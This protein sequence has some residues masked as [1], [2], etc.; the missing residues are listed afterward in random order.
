MDNGS[1][2]LDLIAG[3]ARMLAEARDLSEIRNI[4]SIAVAAAAYARARDLG[5][6]A[7]LSASRIVVL[8]TERL[9][10]EIIAGQERG[11]IAKPGF[12]PSIRDDV[13]GS[14]IIPATLAELGISRDLSSAAQRLASHPEVVNEYLASPAVPSMVGALR[15]VADKAAKDESEFLESHAPEAA[16]TNRVQEALLLLDRAATMIV[17]SRPLSADDVSRLTIKAR[18]VSAVISDGKDRKLEVVS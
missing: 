10:E 7:V 9:G 13:E 17:D 16:R 18:Y 15:A 6:D 12:A 5:Q 1:R 14:D 8:A 2:E 11:E 4:R 3:G